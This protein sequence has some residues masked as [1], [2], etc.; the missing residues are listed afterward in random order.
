MAIYVSLDGKALDGDVNVSAF[1]N[2]G[3]LFGDGVFEVV[4]AFE[5]H[6][7]DP[8]AHIRRLRTSCQSLQLDFPWTEDEILFELGVMLPKVSA[9]KTYFR[10]MVYR[11]GMLGLDDISSE[12]H[13]LIIAAPA[14]DHR[15]VVKS[16]LSLNPISRVAAGECLE[17]I[18][19][20]A[21]R[22]SIRELLRSRALGFDD[23][24]WLGDDGRIHET[25]TANIFFLTRMGDSYTFET[26]SIQG[27]Y[28][29]G[30]TRDIVLMLLKNAGIPCQ[31]ATLYFDELPK[32]DEAFVCST[33]KGLVPI[34]SI[35]SQK[36]STMRPNAAFWHVQ[37]LFLSY[38]E[39]QIGWR[40]DYASGNIIQGEACKENISDEI[41]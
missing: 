18:K 24:L 1:L 8:I 35:G 25:S 38:V 26:P 29:A 19:P 34:R 33:V 10:I 11:G 14:P 12:S 2:R 20:W 4:V 41:H 5:S 36:F 22:A 37:R 39:S 7:F 23:I 15:Q 31:E 6:I 13:K 9:A 3:F 32:Y 21:Y 30:R 28:Y 17:N 40:V 27:S 16:G